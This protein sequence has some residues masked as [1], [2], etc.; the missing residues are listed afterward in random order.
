M[1]NQSSNKEDANSIDPNLMNFITKS[2][3]NYC[4]A[5]GHKKNEDSLK[6]LRK[7]G[8]ATQ[9]I[10]ECDNCGMKTMITALPN[11]GMQINQIRND[12]NTKEF[13]LFTLP[14]TA[15]DYLNFYNEIKSIDNT[16]DLIN[17]I[18]TKNHEPK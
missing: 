13:E 2:W 16:S 9:L 17:K 8:Q 5:C 1:K 7:V 11:L 18:S 12:L 10:S 14:I 15:D 3:G 4:S 6:V